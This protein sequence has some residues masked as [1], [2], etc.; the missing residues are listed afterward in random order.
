MGRQDTMTESGYKKMLYEVIRLGTAP[1]KVLTSLG[2]TASQ[3]KRVLLRAM[4]KYP[5]YLERVRND[6][7][8]PHPVSGKPVSVDKM[9]EI[10]SA[11]GSSARLDLIPPEAIDSKRD[12]LVQMQPS[13]PRD[14]LA[15][16][17]QC[18]LEMMLEEL[19]KR[20]FNSST[21]NDLLRSIPTMTTTMR[22]LREQSTA[23]VATVSKQVH[24]IER[25][26]KAAAQSE[27]RA[28]AIVPDGPDQTAQDQRSGTQRVEGDED[29]DATFEHVP[30][31]STP[32][33]EG[34]Q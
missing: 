25:R 10:I 4:T 32:P 2:M 21:N 7:N 11:C 18:V 19:G 5:E 8:L 6:P 13:I 27:A 9:T 3:G 12:I 15:D 30:G 23:N 20:G 14:H 17:V 26:R 28:L 16:K 34:G 31:P 22:L 29:A 24:E 1:G 33:H